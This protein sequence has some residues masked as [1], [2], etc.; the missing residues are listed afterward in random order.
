MRIKHAES[1]AKSSYVS[2]KP[3]SRKPASPKSINRAIA[4]WLQ[5][6]K[7]DAHTIDN[8]PFRQFI[9]QLNPKY[10]VP[11]SDELSRYTASSQ[12][13]IGSHMTA[14]CCRDGKATLETDIPV[15]VAKAGEALIRVSRAGVCGTDY[16]IAQ[17]YK[18]GF[19]G[20]LGHE[21]VGVVVRCGSRSDENSWL[22]KR[23]VG[24]INLPCEECD[25]CNIGDRH[26]DIR[27]N[28]C[29]NRKCLGIVNHDGAFAEYITLPIANLYVVPL[30]IPDSH[31]VFA[32]PLAA[33][34]RIV[35]QNVIQKSDRVAILGDG[36]LGLLI[37]DVLGEQAL[38]H[39][40]TLIGKH[41]FKLSHATT[42]V[43][44]TTAYTGEGFQNAFDVC[45]ECTGSSSGINTAVEITR[46]EGTIVMKSTCANTKST[47]IYPIN[48]ITRKRLTIRGSRCGP[49]L[50][51]LKLLESGTIDVSRFITAEYSLRR[52]RSAFVSRSQRTIKA[53][54]IIQNT[55]E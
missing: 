36:R 1:F 41:T 14:F 48:S 25:V 21:F 43:N 50:P 13:E 5:T 30:S 51:A 34:C 15:P 26:P 19:S 40:I 3:A 54:I 8:E 12:V 11:S 28:H 18:P 33:A 23:V 16:E 47:A 45:I 9:A 38:D 52:I 17:G 44:I 42:A 27:R 6:S 7:L 31:A 20:I 22:T 4:E 2:S 29:P 39:R 32:E 49:F 24:E 10:I 35:E 46:P 55:F 53:Q 37:A